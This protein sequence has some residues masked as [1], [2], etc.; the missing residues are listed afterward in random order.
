MSEDCFSLIEMHVRAEIE[1]HRSLYEYDTLRLAKD[2]IL[3]VAAVAFAFIYATLA[4]A[5]LWAV[6]SWLVINVWPL[7]AKTLGSL[8][9]SWTFADRTSARRLR[10]AEEE[11]RTL[12]SL[13]DDRM[14]AEEAFVDRRNKLKIRLTAGSAP[15][16]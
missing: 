7:L 6:K 16:R 12:K 9:A 15:R 3:E 14:I 4:P 2:R 11:F 1:R 13:H 10:R 5:A 8:Q